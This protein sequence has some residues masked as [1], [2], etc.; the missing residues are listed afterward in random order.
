MIKKS[1][2]VIGLITMFLLS[3]N[4]T[5]MHKSRVELDYGTSKNLATYNQILNPEA[6][7]NLDPVSGLDGE[8]ANGTVKKYQDSFKKAKKSPQ[9]PISIGTGGKK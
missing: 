9:Y 5:E 2:I 8:S 7:K 4:C 1:F 3:L 6:E